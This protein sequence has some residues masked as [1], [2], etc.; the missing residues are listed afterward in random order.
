M[1]ITVSANGPPDAVDDT[2]VRGDDLVLE[3]LAND[4]DAERRA[5]Q[6]HLGHAA[7]ARHGDHQRRRDTITYA[8]TSNFSAADSFTYTISDS[9]GAHG[10][11]HGHAP[12]LP[13]ARHP[14]SAAA[15]SS[16][17]SAG[18]PARRCMP[19]ASSARRRPSSRLRA[20][21]V[22]CSPRVTSRSR[23]ART[24]RPAPPR[25]TATELRGARDVS[26]LR[27]DL[28]IPA[29]REL[30]L[31]RLRL[32]VRG[33]PRVREQQLQ[34][35]LPGRAR[36]EQLVGRGLDHH[37]A[38]QLRLRLGRRHRLHQRLLL[39]ARPRR[40]GHGQPVRRL[41][42]APERA[43]ARSP[44]APTRSTS[45][46]STR[47]TPRSTRPPSSTASMVG[48]AGPGGCSAGANEP[49]DRGRRRVRR[50]AR[51]RSRL[52]STSSPTTPIPTTA[53]R[54]R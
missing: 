13:G 1:A 4:T 44:L 27:L 48:A 26:I 39:R 34:R 38:E 10:Y 45:P 23:P 50:A 32:P 6:D 25:A 47:A 19:T 40:H 51:T 41:D 14:P 7:R 11:G 52:R 42:A 28:M 18:S 31:L 17:A 30:P 16:R 20:G 46:S 36:R 43:H 15:A 12:G 8:Q 53:T 37:R 54:S 22:P 9:G 24:T 35:R 5:P 33:I 2:Y 49:P 3:V 29:G 21:R